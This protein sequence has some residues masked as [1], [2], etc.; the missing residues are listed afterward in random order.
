MEIRKATEKDLDALRELYKTVSEEEFSWEQNLPVTAFDDATKGE[1]VYVAVVDGE[2]I[3]LLS[4]WEAD[5]FVH[6]LLVSGRARGTGA[7]RAL[8][9]HLRE[10]YSERAMTLKCAMESEASYQFYRHLGWTVLETVD[11]AKVPYYLMQ[12]N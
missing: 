3:G 8:L 2:I 1:V 11:E 4:F 12:W 10:E 7:G 6:N 9:E 5:Y